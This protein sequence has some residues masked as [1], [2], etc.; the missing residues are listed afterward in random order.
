MKRAVLLMLFV[1][2]TA[3]AS[4]AATPAPKTGTL[5]V[6]FSTEAD[7]SDVPSLMAHDRLRAEGYTVETN[8]FLPRIYKSPR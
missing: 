2:L 6:G 3:C 4:P 5:R 8:F 1:C 7:V